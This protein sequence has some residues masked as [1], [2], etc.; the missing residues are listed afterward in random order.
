[1][2]KILFCS[3]VFATSL[4]NA[5]KIEISAAYGTPSLYG[6]SEAITEASGSAIISAITANPTIKYP[7]SNGALNV[8]IHRYSENIHWR[9]GVELVLESFNESSAIYSQQSFISI[10]PKVDYFWTGSDKKLR[11]YSGI[12]AGVL[13]KK[14]E[15][16]VASTG[17]KEN[18]NDTFMAVNLMPIG[19]RYGNKLG[20]FL[21]PNI[22]VK[23]F[24]QAGLSLQF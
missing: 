18:A 8:A 20:I 16:I 23:S 9:Y 10:M 1:M 11:L 5:Q 24:V 6:I 17:T 13:L 2:K 15:Y 3:I 12:A 22:G 7:T 19:V 14:A 21:E 4:Y